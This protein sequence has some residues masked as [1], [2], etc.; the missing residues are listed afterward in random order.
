M[1]K[2]SNPWY[3]LSLKVAANICLY[4]VILVLNQVLPYYLQTSARLPSSKIVCFLQICQKGNVIELPIVHINQFCDISESQ[5][6]LV[7]V[8]LKNLRN[9]EKIVLGT[10]FYIYLMMWFISYLLFSYSGALHNM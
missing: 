10:M 6:M 9:P 1:Y 8:H 4:I 5:N 2:V 3:T 7:F